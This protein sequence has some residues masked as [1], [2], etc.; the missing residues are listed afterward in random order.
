M[1]QSDIAMII[2][3]ISISLLFSYFIGNA[4]FAS[5]EDRT[6]EVEV[7]T[8]ISIEFP[9]IDESIFNSNSLNLT[10]KITIGDT[11][12]DAPFSSDD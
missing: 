7:V 9:D 6:A 4:L 3:V 8:A 2:L 1:K 5:N 11:E 12:S 10:E